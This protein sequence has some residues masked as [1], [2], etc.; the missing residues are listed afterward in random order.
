MVKITQV[1]LIA[2]SLPRRI[3]SHPV[4]APK[5]LS[6]A[7]GLRAIDEAVLQV[8]GNSFRRTADLAK[9]EKDDSW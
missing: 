1:F 4:F 6:I 3:K 8:P 2:C 5:S 7:C 9:G